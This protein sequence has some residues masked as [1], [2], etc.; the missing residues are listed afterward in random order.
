VSGQAAVSLWG[1][2][3]AVHHFFRVVEGVLEGQQHWYGRPAP[4]KGVFRCA[5]K[6]VVTLALTNLKHVVN[7]PSES[8]SLQT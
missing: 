8:S 2:E 1:G 4:P 7:V 3:G 6:S 5:K